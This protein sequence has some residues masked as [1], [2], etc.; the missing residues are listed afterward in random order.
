MEE[1]I[2]KLLT[3]V[4]KSELVSIV[5]PPDE[6]LEQ[7]VESTN[8]LSVVNKLANV[9]LRE[10]SDFSSCPD[11]VNLYNESFKSIP[12]NAVASNVLKYF[13]LDFEILKIP[14]C[15][16]RVLEIIPGSQVIG[17]VRNIIYEFVDV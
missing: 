13:R 15:P 11:S 17:E 1:A 12:F 8:S 10:S 7:L 4:G 3:I 5:P 9:K 6:A 16:A 2:D 14:S